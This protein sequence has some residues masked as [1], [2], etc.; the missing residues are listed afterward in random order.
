MIGGGVFYYLLC[1]LSIYLTDPTTERTTGTTTQIWIPDDITD[2]KEDLDYYEDESYYEAEYE[3]DEDLYED[4]TMKVTESAV[5]YHKYNEKEEDSVNH[6]LL[7]DMEQSEGH[8]DATVSEDLRRN[9]AG[10]EEDSDGISQ[11]L[12]VTDESNIR[13][14][15]I[16]Q[17][18]DPEE[19][20]FSKSEPTDKS[21]YSSLKHDTVSMTEAPQKEVSKYEN[22]TVPLKAPRVMNSSSNVRYSIVFLILSIFLSQI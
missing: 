18:R 13:R 17:D 14:S 21:A 3:S 4:T 12:G 15:K 22:K 20:T 8:S 19:M 9:R 7:E 11:E 2:M 10:T 5:Q 6:V 1:Q 16:L